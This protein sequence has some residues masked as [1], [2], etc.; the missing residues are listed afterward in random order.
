MAADDEGTRADILRVALREFSTRGY[1]QT[2]V[3]EIAEEVGVTKTAVLYHFPSKADIVA[4]LAM[5]MIAALE[6]G[7]A[8]AEVAE[9]PQWAAI[10]NVL[11]TFLTHRY[12][13]RMN[14]HDLALAAFEP[15]L[16]R[17]RD[18]LVRA[19]ALVA[20]GRTDLAG[21]V[22]AA[23]AIAMLSDPVVLFADAPPNALREHILDGV[24]QLF[25]RNGE[26]APNRRT[27]PSEAAARRGRPV[28]MTEAM[29]AKARRMQL[30]GS[31]AD[32]IAAAL[33]VSRA[34]IYRALPAR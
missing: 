6:S 31:P 11:E 28:V 4:A 12:L 30:S 1:H 33:G 29:V 27:K 17:F 5:P 32:A 8:A 9:D 10:G 16:K 14:L 15:S 20:A 19:N 22:R 25:R 24:R 3:R 18:G 21:R 13:F 2:S 23:Q 34:T 26:R 7:L